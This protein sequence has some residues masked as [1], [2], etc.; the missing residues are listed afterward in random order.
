MIKLIGLKRMI[1]LFA[2]LALN[3]S[4][5][6]AYFLSISPMLDDATAQRDAVNGQITDLRSKIDN[7]KQDMAFVTD[8]LPKFN[9]LKDKGFFLPQDRF[10]I[11][12]TMEDLRLKA[13]I[14]NF[15]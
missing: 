6:G 8:N 7:I 13:G 9:D 12:R 14:S 3:L 1:F 2:L 10:M 5:A 11:G 4:A 15:A